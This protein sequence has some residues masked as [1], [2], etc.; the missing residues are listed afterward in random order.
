MIG[1]W[2]EQ[3]RLK[4]IQW[5][6]AFLLQGGLIFDTETTGFDGGAELVQLACINTEGRPLINTYVKP[7]T[8]IPYP[9]T[10]VHGITLETVRSAPTF[11]QVLPGF[12]EAVRGQMVVAFNLDFDRR[13][14]RQCCARYHLNPPGAAGYDCAMLRYAA[15]YGELKKGRSNDFKWQSLSNACEQQGITRTDTHNGLAD[16]LSTLELIQTMATAKYSKERWD[17][18]P[19]LD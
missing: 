4:A 19:G 9:A 6:I 17:M 3:A 15:F 11:K 8:P 14:I 10:Q 16:C 2:L 13:M 12:A 18:L 7:S 5:A 1:D